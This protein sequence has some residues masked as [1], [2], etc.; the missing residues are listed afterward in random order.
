MKDPAVMATVAV[1]VGRKLEQHAVA[2]VDVLA[3]IMNNVKSKDGDRIKAADRIL[4]HLAARG[5]G[6]GKEPHEMTLAD[7][8]ARRAALEAERDALNHMAAERSRPV[9]ELEASTIDE[10]A[11]DMGILG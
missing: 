3:G 11:D 9:M 10:T 1:Q 2:A 6:N 7:I 5:E 4:V 8:E